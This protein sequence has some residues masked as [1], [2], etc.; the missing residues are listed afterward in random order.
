MFL[1]NEN[2]IEVRNEGELQKL[3]SLLEKWGRLSIFR[4]EQRNFEYWRSLML[5]NAF[6]LKVPHPVL[7]L[8]YDEFRGLT[9]TMDAKKTEEWYGLVP[10]RVE[11]LG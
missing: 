2:V 9:F 6:R 5:L 8:E 3:L 11:E 7:L 10:F 4:K 1:Y